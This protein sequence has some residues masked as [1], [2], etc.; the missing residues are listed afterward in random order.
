MKLRLK[1]FFISTLSIMILTPT[2]W[3]GLQFYWQNKTKN[4]YREAQKSYKKKYAYTIVS[5]SLDQ[6]LY[7][8]NEEN[9]RK[10]L[11]YYKQISEY[12]RKVEIGEI[13][14]LKSYFALTGDSVYD[15][16]VIIPVPIKYLGVPQTVYIKEDAEMD[17]LVKVY[18]FN[19]KCWGYFEAYVPRYNLHDTLPPDSVLQNLMKHIRFL[20]VQAD[21]M[22]GKPSPYGFYCN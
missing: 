1:I 10:L 16:S 22:Y 14:Q 8:Y 19:T 17:S 3:Y 18:V 9:G 4:L 15:E 13:K 2:V 7:T 20:H 21:D 12:Y 5:G 11:D 6:T